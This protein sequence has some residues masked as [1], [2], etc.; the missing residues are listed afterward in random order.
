MKKIHLTALGLA[1]AGVIGASAIG[2]ASAIGASTTSNTNVG[3]SGIP[4]TVFKEERQDAADEVL[5]T[6]TANIQA[7][8]KAKTFSTLLSSAGL[9]KTTYSNKLRAQLTSDLEAKGY[10]QDQ[11][12]IALQHKVIVHL[13]HNRK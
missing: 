2:V 11:I 8:H 13:R 1:S 5:N 4:R 12:T 7:A 6:T 9:T 3:K 10:T